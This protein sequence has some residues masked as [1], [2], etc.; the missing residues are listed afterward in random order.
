METAINLIDTFLYFC[1]WGFSYLLITTFLV[2]L[3]EEFKK[4]LEI[5]STVICIEQIYFPQPVQLTKELSQPQPVT[6]YRKYRSKTRT[7]ELRHLC[8]VKGI[9]WYYTSINPETVRKRHMTVE[10]MERAIQLN[11]SST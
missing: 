6:Q 7:T 1:I 9:D 5:S 3:Q 4:H 8:D 10:E 11:N 2:E